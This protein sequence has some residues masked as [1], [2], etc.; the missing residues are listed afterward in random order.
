MRVRAFYLII[1][2]LLLHVSC[3]K[4]IDIVPD[5]VPVID[6]AF[7][8]RVMAKRYLA[9]CYNR[10]PSAISIGQNPGFLSAD[11]FWLNSPT[12]FGS[13]SYPNWYIAMGQQS[14]NA[15]LLNYWG[16]GS[17]GV[18][19]QAIYDCNVFISRIASVPDMDDAEKRIW[20][21]EAKFL[22]AYYHFL[23]LR[24][25]GPILLRDKNIDVFV[26]PSEF[27]EERVSVDQC[28]A[29]IISLID[30]AMNDLMPNE[31]SL[32]EG[33]AGIGRITQLIAKA[34]KVQVLVE[35]A[36]PLFNGNTNMVALK[37]IAGESLFNQVFDANKWQVAA[38]AAKEAI[39][40][41]EANGKQLHRWENLAYL[42]IN[43]P[44]TVFQMNYRT[45]FNESDRNAEGIWYDTRNIV[46]ATSQASF[47][48]RGLNTNSVSN[49]A[50]TSIMGATLNMAEKFYSKNGLPIEEDKDYPYNVRYEVVN[51][52]SGVAY[53]ADLQEGY[54]TVRF[55]IDRE[56]RFYGALSIDGGRYFMASQTSDFAA[57]NKNTITNYKRS[58]NATQYNTINH[59]VTGYMVKKY[60][61]YQNSFGASNVY[62]AR[63]FA[64]PIIRL[65][66]LYLL[67]AESLNESNGPSAEVYAYLDS[68]RTRSG[69]GKVLDTWAN[70]SINPSKPLS[71][72]GLRDIIKR[73]R[74]IELAFEGKR[75]WDLRRWKDAFSEL[76]IQIL[77]WDVTQRTTEAFY[78]P[79]AL[80]TRIF[81]AKDYFWP[82]SLDELRRNPK[83][84]Q[85]LGW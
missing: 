80:Y 40:F 3:N 8:L 21:A 22:K 48:P 2:L 64:F 81:T 6:Q 75:F 50:I 33:E 27:H 41:A 78:R 74:T 61:N 53:R 59:Q 4:F 13:G 35:S 23:L 77:G 56:P 67:Y 38:V 69:L 1:S 25:Y 16:S 52:P 46:G 65:A 39:D 32:G 66:D 83:L 58:G 15:P 57:A 71:Q 34:V 84:I 42:T 29:Y 55:H 24:A 51:V 68:V 28:F 70:Y 19:W 20:K 63:S 49:G 5:N 31:N 44:N 10:L 73:E 45:A 7:S 79:K 9:T 43:S 14:A 11:E 12:N 76:N 18:F 60:V 30:E 54:N 47:Y 85:N 62:T 72:S 82:I 26:E 37:N 36:S 17:N